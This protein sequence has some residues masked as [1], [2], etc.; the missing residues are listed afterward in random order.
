M[1]PLAF[2]GMRAGFPPAGFFRLEEF[3]C[4]GSDDIGVG[5]KIGRTSKVTAKLGVSLYLNRHRS[6]ENSLWSQEDALHGKPFNL[7]EKGEYVHGQLSLWNYG[8]RNGEYMNKHRLL[9]LGVYCWTLSS[10][11]QPIRPRNII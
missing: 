4:N 1:V 8:E 5:M 7:L 9:L 10:G 2:H 11:N 6:S 3:F